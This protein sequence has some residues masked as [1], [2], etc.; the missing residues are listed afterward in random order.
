MKATSWKFWLNSVLWFT[1]FV[2][3]RVIEQIES[4][5][6]PPGISTFW[7]TKLW[8]FKSEIHIRGNS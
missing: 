2:S 5:F 8:M 7:N 1:H 4:G 3:E 6:V